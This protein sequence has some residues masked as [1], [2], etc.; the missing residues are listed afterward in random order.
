MLLQKA[1]SRLPPAYTY[2]SSNKARIL[3][4][5][6]NTDQCLRSSFANSLE[7][8]DGRTEGCRYWNAQAYR[9]IRIL[10]HRRYR[11]A[12]KRSIISFNICRRWSAVWYCEMFMK[13]TAHC[14]SLHDPNILFDVG[15]EL[16]S[17]WLFADM[18]AYCMSFVSTRA[19]NRVGFMI[20]PIP[21]KWN[22][23]PSRC[24]FCGRDNSNY[25]GMESF[26]EV[27]RF[28]LV[29]GSIGK[30]MD[31]EAQESV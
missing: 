22:W 26:L 30:R 7:I 3:R 4:L 24:V 6:Q 8:I 13:W 23:V 29:E 12:V 20:R 15:K 17:W 27:V 21:T 28:A 25:R 2:L 1:K 5:N 16:S 14:C 10:L 19:R 18:E 11:D 31:W 9:D